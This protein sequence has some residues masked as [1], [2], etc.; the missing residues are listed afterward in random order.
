MDKSCIAAITLAIF[1]FASLSGCTAPVNCINVTCNG[2]TACRAPNGIPP[3]VPPIPA[4]NSTAS[5]NSSPGG[6]PGGYVCGMR[7]D[8]CAVPGAIYNCPFEPAGP[9]NGTVAADISQELNYSAQDGFNLSMGT[10]RA[11]SASDCVKELAG[12]CDNNVPSQHI[13]INQQYAALFASQYKEIYP[14]PVPCPL[15]MMAGTLS[16]GL[17]GG[18]CVVVSQS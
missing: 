2:I 13:C 17:D 7:A 8:G 14:R 6:C 11:G 1:A 15:F 18:Y 10:F 4:N 9:A 16:C 3:C 12:R 5:S